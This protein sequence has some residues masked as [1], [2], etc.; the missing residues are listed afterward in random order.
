MKIKF[1]SVFAIFALAVASCAGDEAKETGN[2]KK[3]TGVVEFDDKDVFGSDDYEFVLPRPFALAANFQEAG[4]NYDATRMNP[5]DNVSR[6]NSKGAQLINFG[7]Y[8]TDLVYNVMNE[9]PQKTMEYFVT[10]KDLAENFGMGSIFTEDDLAFEIEQNIADREKMEDLLIEV[11]ERSQEYLDDNDMR[12]LA[13]IQ[14]SGAWIEGMYLVSFDVVE[15]DPKK[16]GYKLVDQM[17]LLEN[18]IHALDVYPNKDEAIGKVL[19]SLKEL[20]TT[21]NN[22]DSVKA[23]GGKGFP[24]LTAS[25]IEVIA[26]SIQEIRQMVIELK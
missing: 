9:K 14:F 16:V 11:H 21:Y 10:I 20:Q 2:K 4:M 15:Q 17:S 13:A 22:F 6:Y 19:T 25:E 12:Y 7:V 5:V 24:D 8:S 1:L 18:T 26:E 23:T 3:V